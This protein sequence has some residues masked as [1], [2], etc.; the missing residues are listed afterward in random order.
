MTSYLIFLS[1]WGCFKQQ[2]GFVP[3]YVISYLMSFGSLHLNALWSTGQR[4]CISW[5]HGGYAFGC[6]NSQRQLIP[7]YGDA[8]GHKFH[9]LLLQPSEHS[10]QESHGGERMCQGTHQVLSAFIFKTNPITSTWVSQWPIKPCG[11]NSQSLERVFPL[12]WKGG[13][14]KHGW[15]F[16]MSMDRM[17]AGFASL[18]RTLCRDPTLAGSAGPSFDG[19][20]SVNAQVNN[21]NSLF[22]LEQQRANWTQRPMSL[23]TSVFECK[24]RR[25]LKRAPPFLQLVLQ[26]LNYFLLS[27]P[28]ETTFFFN[29]FPQ[30]I[31]LVF[32]E[33]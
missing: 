6:H 17:F 21:P 2:G 16:A 11:S 33:S 7:T 28:Q 5:D 32:Y 1:S 20:Q 29:L 14:Q 26:K 25:I 3:N 12:C 4:G 30:P 15:M 31:S 22:R 23:E 24:Y 10:T 9:H 18:A 13:I 8:E 27:F 19:V